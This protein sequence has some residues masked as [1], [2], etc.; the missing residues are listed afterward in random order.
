MWTGRVLAV[1]LIQPRAFGGWI[2]PANRG[3]LVSFVRPGATQL[4][5]FLSPSS[6]STSDKKRGEEKAWLCHIQEFVGPFPLFL[7]MWRRKRFFCGPH[8]EREREREFLR[9]RF[10]AHGQARAWQVT[11]TPEQ[12]LYAYIYICMCMYL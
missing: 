7:F 5:I 9:R 4:L 10:T 8:W 12:N 2:Q 11:R 3:H 1:R 6:L